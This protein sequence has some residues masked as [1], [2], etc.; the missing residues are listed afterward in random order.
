MSAAKKTKR[1]I[2]PADNGHAY[3]AEAPLSADALDREREMVI[4]D[5]FSPSALFV[6]CNSCKRNIPI[7]VG[8]GRFRIEGKF[9]IMCLSCG[10]ITEMQG[11]WGHNLKREVAVREHMRKGISADAIRKIREIRNTFLFS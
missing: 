8:T 6:G 10:N 2:S 5:I 1:K 4:A 7:F 11:E 3:V 9:S